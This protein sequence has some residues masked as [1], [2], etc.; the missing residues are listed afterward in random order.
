MS[1]KSGLQ[2]KVQSLFL[3]LRTTFKQASSVRNLGESIWCEASRDQL[4]GYGEGC[5]RIYVTNETVP[6]GLIWL[7]QQIP[8][9]V[10][11]CTSLES[12]QTWMAAH[13]QSIDQFPAAFCAIETALL[14][15][16]AK[17]QNTS[18]EQLLGLH[19]PTRTYTYTAVLSDGGH[20]K[21][22][23]HVMRYLVGGFS[24]FK[25]KVNGDFLVDK[26]RLDNLLR[27][28]KQKNIDQIRIR[29][30]ANNL[31]KEDPLAAIEHI[32]KLDFNC[33]G[34]EEPIK[35]KDYHGLSQIS[36]SLQ[37]PVILDESLCNLQ[38]LQQ[39]DQ[40]D[41]SFIANIKV[42]RVGGLL[43]SIELIKA[44]KERNHEI[45]IGAHV[46]ETSILT[47]AGMAAAQAAG[48][49][50]VAQEGGFG[51]LLI[52]KDPGMP[53]LMFGIRGQID[54]SQPYQLKT[55]DQEITFPI[56]TWNKGWGLNCQFP[57]TIQQVP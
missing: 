47:R 18:V 38:D 20:E 43:R 53:S 28:A 52:E 56:S 8:D 24:D 17:E 45:I 31:W 41:G 29:L 26:K 5:P 40:V 15:L 2:L 44:L 27:L 14:D 35:P 48:D 23:A 13:R 7:K 55:P 39:L 19:P 54:L 32:R 3:P 11:K 46:G 30:D 21:F 49:H 42:S 6:D 10:K 36:Q 57:K 22:L 4:T 33:F 37:I 9:L 25:V 50:L 1:M 34:I 12:L 16:F 51:L